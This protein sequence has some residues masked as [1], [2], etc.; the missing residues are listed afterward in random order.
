MIEIFNNSVNADRF[1]IAPVTIG[2]FRDPLYVNYQ[3]ILEEHFT[4]QQTKKLL[5]ALLRFSFYIEPVKQ[6]KIETTKFEVR[7]AES[8]NNDPRY[9]S[10][11]NCSLIFQKLLDDLIAQLDNQENKS[12]LEIIINHTLTAYELNIGYINRI[13]D[14]S[15]HVV[16]NS[17]F[18]WGNEIKQVY[19]LRQ[20]LL[21]PNNHNF[22]DFFKI[23]RA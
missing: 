14:A 19:Q 23:G 17:S 16:E 10:Y 2:V 6:P 15:I 4:R 20:Y 22:I 8:L 11:E 7:W 21:N 13:R 9:C 12:L 3:T 5:Q 18:F 1:I